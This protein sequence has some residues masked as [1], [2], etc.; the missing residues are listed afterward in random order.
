M[1][2]ARREFLTVSLTSAAALAAGSALA[3]TNTL[4]GD[5]FG[6]TRDWNGTPATVMPDPA[7]EIHDK[8]FTGRLGNAMVERLWSGGRWTEGPVWM[9]DWRCLLFSDIPTGRILRW[10]EDDGRVTVYS[11]QSNNANGHT[12][13][14]EGRLI[15][16]EHDSRRVTRLEYDGTIT[17]L[18]DA[19]Q[20]KKLNAPNDVVVAADGAVWFTDPGYGILGA[21]EGHKADFEL[22]TN[23]YRIDP[24]SGEAQVAVGDFQRPNGI[25][26][27]PDGKRLYVSDTAGGGDPGKPCHL[28]AFNVG[29]GGKLDGGRVLIDAKNGVIDGFRCDSDGNLWCSWAGDA[30]NNSVRVFSPEGQPLATLHL[31]ETVSNVEFGGPK[32]N[33]LFITGGQSLYATYVNATAARRS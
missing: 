33:R 28:R 9:A 1:A 13:D 24:Q 3:A 22:P 25:A 16:C 27:S 19:F 12:R 6:L 4:S 30:A 10:N 7:W 18:L 5:P 15:S 26:F 32:G 14:R 21:Y 31:P 20:G 11:A 17:V 29:E 23:V 8:A 2:F